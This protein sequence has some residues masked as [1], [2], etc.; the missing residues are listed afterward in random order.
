MAKKRAW[1]EKMDMT[2]VCT[3]CG[4]VAP[5]DEGMSNSNWT[6]YRIKEPC[7]CGGQFISRCLQETER[8]SNG[9]E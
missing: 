1:Y 8:N 6:A 9:T 7:E 2:P 4:K 5:I 3:L